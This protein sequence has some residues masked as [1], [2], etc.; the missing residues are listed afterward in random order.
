MWDYNIPHKRLKG[1]KVLV[2]K[3]GHL[4]EMG[5]YTEKA[6]HGNRG[7]QVQPRSH[8]LTTIVAFLPAFSAYK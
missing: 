3:C 4:F 2:I 7:C 5:G 8:C 6:L 1:T